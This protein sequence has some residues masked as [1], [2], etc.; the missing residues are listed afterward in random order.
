MIRIYKKNDDPLFWKEYIR[1]K[2]LRIYQDLDNEENGPDIRYRLRNELIT[3]QKGLCCYCL[4]SIKNRPSHNEH[5]LPQSKYP[6][7]SLDYK[8][9]FCSCNSKETCGNI[10]KDSSV[11]IVNP[12]VN[13]PE[14]HFRYLANGKIEGTDQIG[15]DTINILN[16]NHRS[17][18]KSRETLLKQ[19]KEMCAYTSKEEVKKTYID[20]NP[21]TGFLP[22]YCGMVEY[23]MREGLFDDSDKLKQFATKLD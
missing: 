20:P 22:S 18:M 8:N 19:C 5:F 2:G 21:N 1:K 17:L 6:N 7:K 9:I 10:K 23:F 16:L 3:E 13:N 12:S 14:S 11:Q 4:S 15:K